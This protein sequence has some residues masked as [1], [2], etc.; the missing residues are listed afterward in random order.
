M[1]VYTIKEKADMVVYYGFAKFNGRDAQR[2][3]AQTYCCSLFLS[4][5]Y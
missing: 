5:R 4:N 1:D 3:Y 2:V